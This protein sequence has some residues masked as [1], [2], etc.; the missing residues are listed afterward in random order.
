MEKL[1]ICVVQARLGSTRL[2]GKVL[3][4][5]GGKPLLIQIVERLKS[6]DLINEVIVATGDIDYNEPIRKVC[7]EYGIKC[8]SGSEQDVLD[9]VYKSVESLNPNNVLRVTADCPFIDPRIV[10]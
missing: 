4:Q 7:F 9:R 8:F 3:L 5:L 10:E 1:N 2:P 6:I